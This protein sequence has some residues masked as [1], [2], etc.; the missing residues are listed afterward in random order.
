M[1]ASLVLA[2]LMKT[3][4]GRNDNLCTTKD[5]YLGKTVSGRTERR[6]GPR[7]V[8]YAL[9]VSLPKTSFP[10]NETASDRNREAIGET[11]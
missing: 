4:S 6:D 11:P 8:L 2:R 7:L 10:R 5:A 3:V 1:I 9:T